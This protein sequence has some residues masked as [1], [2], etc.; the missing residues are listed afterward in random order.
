MSIIDNWILILFD[1]GKK[2]SDVN[3]FHDSYLCV[4]IKSI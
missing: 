1:I 2:P 4:N 3:P